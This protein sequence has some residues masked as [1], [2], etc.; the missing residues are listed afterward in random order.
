MVM[1]KEKTLSVFKYILS[2]L[3]WT[4]LGASAGVIVGLAGAAF[5]YCLQLVTDFRTAHPLLVLGLPLA[6]LLIVFLYHSAGIRES[7]GTN[8]VLAS[9][10]TDEPIPFAMAPLIFAGTVLTHLFGGSAG[11]EGAAL[12][13]GG[14][15]AQNL[16]RKLRLSSGSQKL[17]TMC[18]MSACFSALFGTPM[19]AAFF[20]M[21]VI[22]V[23][24]M[25]Y[26]ALVPCAVASVTAAYLSRLLG[27][28]PARFSVSG[29]PSEF[30]VPT[31][32]RVFALAALCAGVSILFCVILKYTSAFYASCFKNSYL[33]VACG[34]ILVAVF[35][36][37]LRS[38]D[39]LGA[40]TQIIA[41][42]FAG[43][44]VPLAFLL[45]I[46]FTAIT[47]EAGFK[48]GEIVPTFFIGATFGCTAGALL[49]LNPSFAAAVGMLCLF[50]GVTNCP[51]T[52]LFLSLELFGAR[53]LL[54]YFLATAV[55][56][57]LSGYFSLYSK[58]K[59]MYSKVAPEFIDIT[60]H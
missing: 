28:A 30:S 54:W 47:L 18:G 48:G 19:S 24:I 59:I 60:A 29:I 8:L 41:R 12:Q 4:A 31:M 32:L 46:I 37:I 15:I 23:G 6:G 38:Q 13:L 34:G 56:Y 55:S 42:A 17:L 52:T 57:M 7:R 35:A 21:E 1:G 43:E 11:R 5:A 53:G 20:A 27:I 16:A 36:M 58:Q 22:S 50:C 9:I 44:A 40:G 51:I 26:S 33:R 10:R 25:H 45:K 49:G 14:S 39:Y 3:K 2:F